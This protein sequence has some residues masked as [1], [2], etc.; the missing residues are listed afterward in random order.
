MSLRL[1]PV[2]Q[3]GCC[4]RRSNMPAELTTQAI[5]AR[6]Q[7][8]ENILPQALPR[9]RRMAARWLDNRDDAEDVIQDAMLS[10]FTHIGQF[11]GRAKLSTWLSAIVINAVRM[12]M[13]RRRRGPMFSL[14]Y[15]PKEGRQPIAELLADPRPTPEKVVERFE[16]YTLIIKLTRGLA[17][18]QRTALRLYQRNGHS[19]RKLAKNLGVPEG[20]LK[21]NLARG[22]AKLAARF[23][24]VMAKPTIRGSVMPR[25]G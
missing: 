2:W 17:P 22:R 6:R 1:L 5:S 10:A 9:F 20:T 18:S 15:A 24:K 23:H 19:I 14:D 3:E 12:Q 21:A 25:H 13:R 16:L 11:D 7:E 4:N 8:F